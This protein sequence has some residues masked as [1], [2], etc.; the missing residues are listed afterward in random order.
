M[1]YI[2]HKIKLGISLRSI[3]KMQ[4]FALMTTKFIV[5]SPVP[6]EVYGIY[7]RKKKDGD[8]TF[9]SLLKFTPKP[10]H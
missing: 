9:Y 5:R 2:V 1:A 3:A 4:T 7:I 6:R 8:S 10:V